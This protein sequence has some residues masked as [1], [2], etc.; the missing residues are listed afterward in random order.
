SEAEIVR[1]L[2]IPSPLPSPLSPWSSPLTPWSS[3]L[4]H[5]PSP[6]LPVSSPVPVSPPPLPVSPTYPLG[7]RAAIIW[8]RVKTPSISHPLPSSTPPSGTPPLLPMPLPTPS[9]PLLL[10]STVCSAGTSE[11]TLPPQKRL[12]IALGLRYKVGESSSTPTAR[13]TIGFRA[14]YGFVGTLDDEIRRDPERYDTNEIYGRLDDAQDDRLLM[15]GWLNMLHRDRRAHDRIA[16]LMERE[17]RDFSLASS[18]PYSTGTSCGDTETDE[19]TT[20]IGDNT[21]G[22]TGTH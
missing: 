1:L 8:L 19:Y 4:P 11:V 12:C 5:I 16:L 18:I 15:R 14:D 3:P 21:A 7:Y 6:P 20:D 17:D 22:T 13:P 9:P 10:P 2:S